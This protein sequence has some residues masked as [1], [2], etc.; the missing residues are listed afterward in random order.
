[1]VEWVLVFVDVKRKI[2]SKFFV[3]KNEMTLCSG[4][5]FYLFRSVEG[6]GGVNPQM[7]LPGQS[8]DYSLHNLSNFYLLY[9]L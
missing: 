3:R 2:A 8:T 6:C 4:Y 7:D 5:T 9:C 1:M